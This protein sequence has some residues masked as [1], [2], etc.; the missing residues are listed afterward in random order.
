M[1]RKLMIVNKKRLDLRVVA[2]I[3]LIVVGSVMVVKLFLTTFGSFFVAR[4]VRQFIQVPA[5]KSFIS[6][7]TE[8]NENH[9][10]MV[11]VPVDF[12]KEDTVTDP[13]NFR[14]LTARVDLLAGQPVRLNQVEAAK[15]A[16]SLLQEKIP[17]GMRAMTLNVD[18]TSAVEGWVIPGSIVD[19]LLVKPDGVTQVVAEKIKV[20]SVGGQLET[21]S[22]APTVSKTLTVLVSQEQ[23]LAIASAMP[24][25]KLAFTLRG[26]DDEHSWRI[27]QYDAEKIGTNTKA[28]SKLEGIV[29]YKDDSGKEVV[30]TLSEGKLIPAEARIG[31]DTRQNQNVPN[32]LDNS[33]SNEKSTLGLQ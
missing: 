1:A 23:A 21:K 32:Q 14:G 15:K 27:K 8:L 13:R 24:L 19:I 9:F 7:G 22:D 12:I 5:P 26:A 10:E 4:D 6:A 30:Y 25:G 11:R 16:A 33:S 17:P 31:N 28:T 2:L 18:A 3:V 20:I 29:R